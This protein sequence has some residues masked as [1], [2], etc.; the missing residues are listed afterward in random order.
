MDPQEPLRAFRDSQADVEKML[1]YRY[2]DKERERSNRAAGL[3]ERAVGTRRRCLPYPSHQSIAWVGPPYDKIRAYVCLN[4]N[5]A[6]SEPE[7]KDR[8]YEFDTI[9]DYAIHT[10]FDLDLERQSEQQKVYRGF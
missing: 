2:A 4:C 10:I 9:P 8:G 6:A 5:A 7:I 1:R 3:H